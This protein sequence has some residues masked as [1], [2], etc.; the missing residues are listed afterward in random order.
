MDIDD[1]D[2]QIYTES[3]S[4]GTW[5]ITYTDNRIYQDATDAISHYLSDYINYCLLTEEKIEY[6]YSIQFNINAKFNDID[7]NEVLEKAV[8][9]ETDPYWVHKNDWNVIGLF[10]WAVEDTSDTFEIHPALKLNISEED[11]RYYPLK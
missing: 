2:F 3:D 11:V 7:G 8:K 9:V 10:Y 1:S 4:S 6:V 5:E